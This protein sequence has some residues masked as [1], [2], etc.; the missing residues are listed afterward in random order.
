MKRICLL[1]S[2]IGFFPVWEAM[3]LEYRVVKGDNLSKIGRLFGVSYKEIMAAN[4]LTKTIIYP[5]QVLVIPTEGKKQGP[6]IAS[7]DS[8]PR[9]EQRY[10]KLGE[11]DDRVVAPEIPRAPE[12]AIRPIDPVE[13]YA[14]A[15]KVESPNLADNSLRKPSNDEDPLGLGYR[16]SPYRNPPSSSA[17]PVRPIDPAPEI[18]AHRVP[19][20]KFPRYVEVPA[21]AHVYPGSKPPEKAPE[22]AL[23]PN[24]FPKPS[25]KDACKPRCVSSK[26]YHFV[27]QGDSIWSISR[28]YGVSPLKLRRTNNLL[29]SKIRPGMKL[30]I[31]EGGGLL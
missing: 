13:P 12:I 10:P 14:S 8:F 30:E 9:I 25:F 31:P 3:G 19:Q 28:K 17:A 23:D 29:F 7:R 15:R 20:Q 27:Q 26:K 16:P 22:K 21:A 4:G 6:E 5:D 2:L 18:R 11:V 1:V 24:H